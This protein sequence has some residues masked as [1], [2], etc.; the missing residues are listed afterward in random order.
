MQYPRSYILL[1]LTMIA[2]STYNTQWFLS[3]CS[4]R[5]R[6]PLSCDG[7]K[8][9]KRKKYPTPVLFSH[10]EYIFYIFLTPRLEVKPMLKIKIHA[11]HDK[12]VAIDK[13]YAKVSDRHLNGI[14]KLTTWTRS[15]IRWLK[16]Y[17]YFDWVSKFFYQWFQAI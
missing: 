1:H 13:P 10:F 4:L 15:L 9:S 3:V 7:F 6:W 16:I 11:C 5:S 2:T 8:L 14:R 12:L 17:S